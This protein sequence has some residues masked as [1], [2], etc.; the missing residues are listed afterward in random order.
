MTVGEVRKLLKDVPDEAPLLLYDHRGQHLREW[1]GGLSV[2]TVTPSASAIGMWV[3][4][5]TIRRARAPVPGASLCDRGEH[6]PAVLVW[7]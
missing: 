7:P 1:G 6:L 3:P 5:G 4:V 2:A